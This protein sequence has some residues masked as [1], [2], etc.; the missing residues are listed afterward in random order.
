MTTST[1]LWQ[2]LE[3]LLVQHRGEQAELTLLREANQRLVAQ[4]Y[5]LE[6]RE[7]LNTYGACAIQCASQRRSLRQI[8]AGEHNACDCGLA[9][10]LRAGQ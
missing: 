1:D 6:Q 7:A 8:E 5:V 3:A 4:H 2:A 10:A 9:D